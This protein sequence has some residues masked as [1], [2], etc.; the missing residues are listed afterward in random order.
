MRWTLCS[1]IN[2][3]RNYNAIIWDGVYLSFRDGLLA[4]KDFFPGLHIWSVLIEFGVKMFYRLNYICGKTWIQQSKNMPI[5][6]CISGGVFGVHW[7][8]FPSTIAMA[9]CPAGI[10]SS[11]FLAFAY[12]IAT[13]P[14]PLCSLRP[15]L[16]YSIVCEPVFFHHILTVSVNL[17][18]CVRLCVYLRIT[19]EAAKSHPSVGILWSCC[20][21]HLLVMFAA[22][23]NELGEARRNTPARFICIKCMWVF[24][25]LGWRINRLPT[26]FGYM[27]NMYYNIV[28]HIMSE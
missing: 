21:V 28:N 2:K 26:R 22:R 11:F 25:V 5:Y 7:I 6:K 3:R 14:I 8:P 10:S 24:V 4:S 23:K 16:R 27:P 9:M 1:P 18:A 15:S 19:V 17:R 20:L 13:L 12:K